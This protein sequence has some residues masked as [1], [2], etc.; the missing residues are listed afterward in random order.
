M[1]EQRDKKIRQISRRDFRAFLVEGRFLSLRK[2]LAMCRLLLWRLPK[3]DLV[4]RDRLLRDW[5]LM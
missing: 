1:S 5:D 4:A 3:H 2:R